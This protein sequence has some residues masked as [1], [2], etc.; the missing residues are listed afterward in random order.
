MSQRSLLRTAFALV[1]VAIVFLAG[2]LAAQTLSPAPGPILQAQAPPP[3]VPVESEG[4]L[5]ADPAREVPLDQAQVQLS[6][7][8]VVRAV[9]PSVVNVYATTVVPGQSELSDDPFFR[10]FGGGG[11]FQ[12]RPQTSQSL[13]SGVIVDATGVVLTNSHVVHG[14]TD[15]RIATADGFE[16]AVDIALDDPENDLAVL[17]VRDP[18]GRTFPALSFADS[19]DLQVGDLVLAI[20]NPFGVGQTVTSGI[21]SAL[22]RSGV[23]ANSHEFFIQTDA[24]IN[25]GN[26]GG[27]LVDL[28]GKLVGIN[29]AILSRT[30][31]SVGIGFA[32]PANMAKIVAEA[33]IAGG[34]LVRPWLGLRTQ[35]VTPDIAQSIGLDRPRGAMVTEVAPG[36][37]AERAG[38]QP[39]DV[40]LSIGDTPIDQASAFDFRVATEPVGGSEQVSL[41][42]RG[43]ELSVEMALEPAPTSPDDVAQV[44]GNTRF[45]GTTVRSITPPL[46][47][48]LGLP[49]DAQGVVVAEVAPNS[50]A[51]RMGLQVGD[52]ILNL[53]GEDT[54]D[55]QRFRAIASARP[56]A[57]Q[58]ELRRGQRVFRSVVAG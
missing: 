42:R 6:F 5:I 40:I 43:R 32:I 52:I 55:A 50:P 51:D 1:L 37:P 41:L 54:V 29:T 35:D 14:A 9:T 25:P 45:A 28:T 30:G 58:I 12:Q 22:A 56:Q 21:V 57:W 44:E 31:G 10:F 39:G 7:A 26:S 34:T 27:A 16:Y 19:D 48:E 20:G 38:L 8:P 33:G 23:E 17:R 2:V 49:F 53:N 3:V 46:A 15:V 4:P 24:A 11:L 18:A 13:G 47:Q 36:G